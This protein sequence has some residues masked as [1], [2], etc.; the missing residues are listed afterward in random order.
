[1]APLPLSWDHLGQIFPWQFGA[2]CWHS[3]PL[4]SQALSSRP[5]AKGG[6]CKHPYLGVII[7][8]VIGVEEFQW[9]VTF[10]SPGAEE[11]EESA[12]ITT[13]RT[14]PK[15][16]TT[17]DT[18]RAETTTVKMQTKVPAQTKVCGWRATPFKMVPLY[19][20]DGLML[21]LIYMD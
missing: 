13:S 7:K 14:L 5:F 21:T 1:M 16:L 12:V 20:I 15:L 3:H 10:L 8:N 4:S 11:D 19:P 9:N 17:S 6:L 2:Y 18:S